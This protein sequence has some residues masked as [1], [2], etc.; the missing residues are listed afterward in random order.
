MEGDDDHK[1]WWT[2][3]DCNPLSILIVSVQHLMKASRSIPLTLPSTTS[4][5][6]YSLDRSAYK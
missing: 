6:C 5:L 1:E 4:S 3:M 2:V